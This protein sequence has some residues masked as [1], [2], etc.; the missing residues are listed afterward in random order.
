VTRILFVCLGNICRSPAAEAAFRHL[1]SAEGLED[2]FLIDSAGT[3]AWHIGEPADRRM[4][5]AAEHRGLAVTS[6]AR[7]VAADDFDRFDL[8]LAMDYDNLR[9][10]QAR[11]PAAHAHKIRLFREFDPEGPGEDVPDPYYGDPD[12]FDDVLDIVTRTGRALLD[13]L[14][15]RS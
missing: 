15:A 13:D 10:L 6:L 8:L 4:R 11:A 9:A 12:G 5:D 3:G 7:Q 2:Q 14:R 1:V